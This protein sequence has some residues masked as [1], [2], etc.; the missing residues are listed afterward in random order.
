MLMQ[1]S[2]FKKVCRRDFHFLNYD[3]FW[4]LSGGLIS[5]IW[6]LN[7]K[8][9]I[10]VWMSRCTYKKCHTGFDMNVCEQGWS[11]TSLTEHCCVLHNTY[12]DFFFKTVKRIWWCKNLFLVLR[13]SEMSKV[14]AECL[15]LEL[16]RLVLILASLLEY[17][18]QSSLWD[19]H[20]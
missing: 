17:F 4:H 18:F 16:R 14:F 9:K 20:S 5:A 7:L 11:T 10:Q 3:T 15:N 8:W 19:F 1:V 6:K 2:V 12:S 13:S